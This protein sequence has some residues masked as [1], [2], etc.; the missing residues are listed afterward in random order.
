MYRNHT[1]IAVIC[2][3]GGSKG[4][5]GK[6]TR[7]LNGKPLVAYT[8]ERAK[9]FSYADRIVVSTDDTEIKSVAEKCGVEIPCLRP[10][11]LATD[12]IS[13]IPAIIHAVKTAEDYWKEKYDIV[14]NLGPTCP[15]RTAEDIRLTIKML[16]DTPNT[17]A[18]FSVSKSHDNPYFNMVEI[19]DK[20][21]VSI[22]KK[23]NNIIARRQDAPEVYAMNGS[24]Y[25]IW[26]QVLLAEKSFFTDKTRVYVMPRERSIDI[27]NSIDFKLAEFLMKKR[28]KL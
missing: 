17:D 16:V 21:Y 9:K 1:V 10:K 13:V 11:E 24:V 23:N 27:D 12:E 18:V 5:P 2:A 7:L 3:R 25:S 4:F 8:I 14:V 6:N 15:L 19:D 22:S 20:K 28:K 26:K